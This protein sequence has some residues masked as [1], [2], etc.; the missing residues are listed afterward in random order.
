M[1][2]LSVYDLSTFE[3]IFICVG[4][5]DASKRTDTSQFEEKFD[6]LLSFINIPNPECYVHVCQVLPH[7]DVDVSSVNTS[8]IRVVDQWK[9]TGSSD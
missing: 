4:G 3:N 9:M 1:D 6:E 2:E 5:N 7:G 8:I